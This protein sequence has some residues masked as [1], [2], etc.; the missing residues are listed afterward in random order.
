MTQSTTPMRVV[1]RA[2]A[3]LQIGTGHVMRCLTLATGLADRGAQ[4]DFICRAHEGNLI[5]LIEQRG[6]RVI[7]LLC[8]S[9]ADKASLDQPVHAHW[10]GC[11]WQTDAQQSLGAIF[12]MVDWLIVDH[13][14]LDHRWETAM[15]PKC[16]RIM[17]IDDLA[18]RSHDCDLLLDQSLGRCSQDY[19]HLVPEP[20]KLLLGPKYAL[21]RPEFAQWRDASLARR[22]TPQLRHILVTM[23]GVDSDNVTGRVLAALQGQETTTLDKI[24]V[25]L[26]PHAPW[27]EQVTKQ[28]A[29]M[30]VPTQVLSGVDNMA[31]LMASCDLIIGA[32]GSTTWE[33]CALG[34]PS[35][36]IILAENQRTI[37]VSLEKSGAALVVDPEQ[38]FCSQ[39]C[40]ALKHGHDLEKLQNI[41][42][43]CAAICDGTGQETVVSELVGDYG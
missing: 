16:A 23:G 11:D 20:A 1:V 18:D 41:I 24:T 25:V 31:E 3:S 27:R 9:G 42:Q 19:A 4:V 10:L 32:G 43:A 15:R 30:P 40:D 22:E 17:C 33:R 5:A 14:A 35:I 7:T 38:S 12:G 2:D 39:F 8:A 34:V 28:A 26:G 37:G 13:Y 36:L 29:A 6:F 21:L